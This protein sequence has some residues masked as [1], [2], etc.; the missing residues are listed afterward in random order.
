MGLPSSAAPVGTP[1]RPATDN[2]RWLSWSAPSP[3]RR[4]ELRF[5]DAGREVWCP[6]RIK[7]HPDFVLR[8]HPPEELLPAARAATGRG[9]I[10][11]I[12]GGRELGTRAR[13]DRHHRP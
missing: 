1:P 11:A 3:F 9:P 4:P 5:V 7:R 12:A 10:E 2:R 6:V 8:R 13:D